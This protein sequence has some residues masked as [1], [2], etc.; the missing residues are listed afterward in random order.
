MKTC[1]KCGE[2]KPLDD[3]NRDRAR[4]DGRNPWCRECKAEG[5]RRYYEE[6]S[7]KERE[8]QR[9]YW[10][11]N[12][13][14]RRTVVCASQSESQAISAEM[15]TVPPHTPWTEEEEAF[16]MADNGMTTFQKAI[17]LGRTY[18]SCGVRR[19]RLRQAVTA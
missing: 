5:N 14:Y 16:L 19:R 1:T 11:E 6:N 7:G 9:R 10:E 12:R 15:A 13:D 17:H 2:T 4:A 18:H 3:F 8:R